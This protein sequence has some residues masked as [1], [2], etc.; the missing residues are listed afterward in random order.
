MD[1]QKAAAEAVESGIKDVDKQVTALRTRKVKVG[2]G[3]NAKTEKEVL[4]GPKAQ[5]ALIAID[6]HTGEV[7]ALV[8]GRNYGDS[9]LNHAVAERPTGFDLQAL[10]LCSRYQHRYHRARG[11][12][13][14]DDAGLRSR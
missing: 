11:Q 7:L 10:R 12:P 8:G 13:K 14:R 6:P 5:V 1:L 4:P 9:Q 2:K 3:K